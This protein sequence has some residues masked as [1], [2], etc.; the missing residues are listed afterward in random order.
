MFHLPFS[1]FL[2]TSYLPQAAGILD[3]KIFRQSAIKAV[4]AK[5]VA[6]AEI[7]FGCDSIRI[8]KVLWRLSGR[9]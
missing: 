8:A 7:A 5:S 4:L 3:G 9:N 2:S 1:L 6:F